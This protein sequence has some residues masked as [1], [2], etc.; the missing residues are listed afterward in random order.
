M[1]TDVEIQRKQKLFGNRARTELLILLALL[2]ESY[3][4]ELAHLLQVRPFSVQRI[5]DSLDGDG[6]TV[7]RLMGRVR[8]V[9]LNPR[10]YAY[11]QLKAL[12]LR[13]AE[14]EPSMQDAAARR[15][16]RPR[17]TNKPL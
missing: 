13:L 1:L 11:H 5:I 6:I 14:G 7:S 9:T 2:E 10:F 15:R 3:P 4:S 8:R 12:L 17:R 16:S